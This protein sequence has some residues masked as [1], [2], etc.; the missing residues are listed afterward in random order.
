MGE[1]NDIAYDSLIII[2]LT[3]S[4]LIAFASVAV[5][6]AVAFM[7]KRREAFLLAT[8]LCLFMSE[9]FEIIAYAGATLESD[10][11][12][13]FM[14]MLHD[15]LNFTA[16]WIFAQQYLKTS[17]ILPKLFIEAKLEYL[18]DTAAYKDGGDICNFNIN[19]IQDELANMHS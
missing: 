11:T 14:V 12:A 8:P 3:S 4:F 7:R 17:L 5:F 19:K 10:F 6:V 2:V 1:A 9:V 13:N 16:L 18:H 15:F